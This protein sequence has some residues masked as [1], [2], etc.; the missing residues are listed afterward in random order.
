MDSWA[1][2]SFRLLWRKFLWILLRLFCRC[3]PFLFF[4]FDKTQRWNYWIII[5]DLLRFIRLSQTFLWVYQFTLITIKC[6]NSF[7]QN[8]FKITKSSYFT[9]LPI[10]GVVR[11]LPDLS[12]LSLQTCQNFSHTGGYTVH[13]MHEQHR[14]ERHG[15]TYMLIF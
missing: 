2:S 12:D 15:S 3:F 5:S 11:L 1:V 8:N 10:F 13:L 9:I 14:F 7:S 6:E 4:F